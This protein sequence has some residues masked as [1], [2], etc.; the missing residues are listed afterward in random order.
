MA[1]DGL[2]RSCEVC[3]SRG[4]RWARADHTRS[5]PIASK[6]G[7]CKNPTTACSSV[8]THT[9]SGLHNPHRGRTLLQAGSPWSALR[10]C[11]PCCVR[12]SDGHVCRLPRNSSHEIANAKPPPHPAFGRRC[13][14][15]RR[16]L[17]QAL[18]RHTHTYNET[19]LRHPEVG[20]TTHNGFE[21]TPDGQSSTSITVSVM[22]R[23]RRQQRPPTER[24]LGAFG[25]TPIAEAA[26][27]ASGL[28]RT[29]LATRR[30]RRP[31]SR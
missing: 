21:R 27:C 19:T 1:W 26:C 20:E 31:T 3:D 18:A 16:R 8:G 12:A 28:R 9:A 22:L 25:T 15:L 13:H 24:T 4:P 17:P 11:D 7:A 10:L 29:I 5:C 23:P 6:H 30:P 2:T 14:R